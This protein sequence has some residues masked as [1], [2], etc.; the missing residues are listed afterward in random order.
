MNMIIE[1]TQRGTVSAAD[2]VDWLLSRGITLVSTREV[3]HL[4]G[5][6]EDHVRQRLAPLRKRRLLATAGKGLWVPV[7]SDRR[8]WGAP[9][10]IAY[11]DAMMKQL[12]AQYCIGWLS[13]A[14]IHGVGHQAAQTFDVA[15][16]RT[17]RD[18][19]VGRSMLRFRQRS[20]VASVPAERISLPAGRANVATV[21]ACMLML[22]SDVEISGGLDN[23]VTAIV[24]LSESAAFSPELLAD[25]SGL[26]SRS[27]ARR[28]GW[29]LDKFG[30]GVD[31][32]ALHRRCA[33]FG[34]VPSMLNPARPAKGSVDKKWLVIENGEVDPDL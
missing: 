34:E 14:A 33:S 2:L 20:D 17:L 12:G 11:I 1:H 24:E 29:V 10:P 18:R 27:A 21:Q 6:R 7:P 8:A 5:V 4:L 23:A 31:T 16:S 26:F 22:A 32:A 3:A 19:T 15:V 13:A 30:D 25:A 28:V 9:E